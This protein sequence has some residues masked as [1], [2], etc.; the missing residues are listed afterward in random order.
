M[1]QTY[2]DAFTIGTSGT[3]GGCMALH[4][5]TSATLTAVVVPWR[6]TPGTTAPVALPAGGILP[7]K[8]RTV[9]SVSANGLVGFN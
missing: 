5:S 6:N 1:S 2:S 9:V 4:N 8:V 7:L 3:S